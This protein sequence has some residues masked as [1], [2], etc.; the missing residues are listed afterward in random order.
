MGPTGA[1]T[2]RIGANHTY[3]PHAAPRWHA[4]TLP[5]GE[6][7]WQTCCP[8]MYVNRAS[9]PNT[10]TH[11]SYPVCV[12]PRKKNCGLATDD[13]LHAQVRTTQ[14]LW[15]TF[16]SEHEHQPHYPQQ[17][18]HAILRGERHTL[19]PQQAGQNTPPI[20]WKHCGPGPPHVPPPL[21]IPLPA[22]AQVACGV[23]EHEH[24]PPGRLPDH[25]RN[26]RMTH[27]NQK[28]T[29]HQR[30]LAILPDHSKILNIFP[31]NYI[32]LKQ[33]PQTHTSTSRPCAVY[34]ATHEGASPGK[35]RSS[36]RKFS[37][38]RLNASQ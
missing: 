29:E 26:R 24:A 28:R 33:M 34:H 4:R 27:P 15:S 13:R 18:Q 38:Q 23:A 7:Q 3:T 20:E 2:H 5:Q 14:H 22:H 1:G 8:Y 10:S 30:R 16:C 12:Q 19:P 35:H 11:C 36:K 25:T 31:V 32:C 21:T 9:R 6:H 37:N 17:K